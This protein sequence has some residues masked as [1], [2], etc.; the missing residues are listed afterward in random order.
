[1]LRVLVEGWTKY[2]H[3]YCVVNVYQLIALSKIPDVKLYYREV[4]PF[5]PNWPA[6]QSVA[7]LLLTDAEENTLK[8][9]EQYKDGETEIDI[10]YR[11]SFQY[12]LKTM[13]DHTPVAVFY[14]AEFQKMSATSFVDGTGDFDAFENLVKRGKLAAI[15]PSLWSKKVFKGKAER[16][17]GNFLKVI[18]HGV[19]TTKYHPD[20]LGRKALRQKMKIEP[21]DVIFLNV[22]SMTL[23]K[24]IPVV[25]KAFYELC[26]KHDNVRLWLKGINSLYDCENTIHKIVDGLV[27][28]NEMDPEVFQK[29]VGNKITYF[30]GAMGFSSMR[31]L[32]NAADCYLSP[33]MAEGFNMPVLEAQA[34]G[35]PVI[36]PK[37]GPTD[38]FIHP[39]CAVWVDS[40]ESVDEKGEHRLFTRP[41]DV[42]TAMNFIVENGTDLINRA[43]KIGPTHVE[44][45][46]TWDIV[47]QKMVKY[48]KS[49]V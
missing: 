39:E 4:E 19:D 22:G 40:V 42:E 17:C 36:V 13:P 8:S 7:G 6:F 35:I 34:C 48:F 33:Y 43:T 18:P 32:Y 21:T 15:A 10:V 41:A 11:I 49:I 14:T 1:M 26:K 24:N 20:P 3:S 38:E 9:I 16:K 30:D 23:N 29:C 25:I 44:E 12:N 27:K 45:H 37:F 5:R 31:E 47:A 2:A 28:S 46:F